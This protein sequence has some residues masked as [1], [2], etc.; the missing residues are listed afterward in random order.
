M[1]TCYII[2][3]GSFDG[4]FDEIGKN[5]LVLAADRGYTLAKSE[6]INVDYIIGDFDSS[7]RP[8]DINV[9]ALNPVKDFTDTV[10]AIEFAKEKGF[11][12]IIIYGGLGGRESHTISNIRTIYHYQKQGINVKLKSRSKEIFVVDDNF[13][14]TYKNHDFYVSIFSLN[15]KTRLTIKGLYYELEDY[16]MKIDDALGVSN[17][18]KKEDFEIGVKDGAVVVV[19]EDKDC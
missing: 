11:R 3:G 7:K 2:G 18:T 19:F 14:Y 16:K 4:F 1:K 8:D 15:D 10:A 5:D 6:N 12:E 17:E 13:S 9:I